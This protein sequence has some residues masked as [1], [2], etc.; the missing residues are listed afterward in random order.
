MDDRLIGLVRFDLGDEF[1]QCQFYSAEPLAN[2]GTT[3]GVVFLW[4]FL[5]EAV[6]ATS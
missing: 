2:L 5:A 1:L 4:K 6:G 3:R